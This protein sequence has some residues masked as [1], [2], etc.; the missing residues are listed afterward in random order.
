[1]AVGGTA[2]YDAYGHPQTAVTLQN[3]GYTVAVTGSTS[4]TPSTIVNPGT[5][6]ATGTTNIAAPF[7]VG[8][9]YGQFQIT[10][11]GTQ[12]TTGLL[13]TIYFTAPYPMVRPALVAITTNTGTPAAAG[14]TLVVT[15]EPNQLSIKVGTHL[16]AA[17]IYNVA[18]AIL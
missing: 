15:M 5:N 13:R 11:A 6:D 2:T 3:S 14:G 8:D 17:T 4:K 7:M 9:S 18:Y 16:T 12:S 10:P 1:M